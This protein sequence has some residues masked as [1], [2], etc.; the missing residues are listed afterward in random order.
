MSNLKDKLL[1]YPFCA[2]FPMLALL[3]PLV[4]YFLDE[5]MYVSCELPYLYF[6][7]LRFIVC[8]FSLYF[9]LKSHKNKNIV[10][11]W[12]FGS[13]AILFNPI[14]QIHLEESDWLFVDLLISFLFLIAVFNLKPNSVS[15]KGIVFFSIKFI[16]GLV[17]VYIIWVGVV[18]YVEQYKKYEKYIA[19][20]QE[21]NQAIVNVE[22][23]S[24][25]E[26]NEIKEKIINLKKEQDNSVKEKRSMFAVFLFEINELEHKISKDEFDVVFKEKGYFRDLVD[27]MQNYDKKTFCEDCSEL[28]Y[29]SHE[30]CEETCDF[31][32]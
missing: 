10:W 24:Q 5:Y 2:I 4:V 1:F 14:F 26:I 25:E 28:K 29:L 30:Y 16:A 12:V 23:F 22:I 27:G 19:L 21:Y 8:A 17:I 11:S 7:L 13:V 32:D 3:V 18:R 20:K 9:A 31:S 15:I 6:I